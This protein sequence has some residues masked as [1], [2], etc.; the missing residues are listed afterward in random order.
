MAFAFAWLISYIF[1]WYQWDELSCVNT[2][3][4]GPRP[5]DPPKGYEQKACIGGDAVIRMSFALACTHIITLIAMLPRSDAS[6]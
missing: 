1:T 5:I 6:A 4:E 2:H 3:W